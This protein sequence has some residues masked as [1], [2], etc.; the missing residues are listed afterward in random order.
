MYCC[1]VEKMYNEFERRFE[2]I[3]KLEPIITFMSYPFSEVNSLEDI[4][5]PISY[6]FDM[7]YIK[8]ESEIIKIKSDI[9]LKARGSEKQFLNLRNEKKYSCF[10]N[11]ALQLYTYFGFTYMCETAFSHMKIIKS[12][13]RPT[14]SND[15]L[16]QCLRLA[17]SNY[18]QDYNKIANDM[19]CH[20]STSK[21]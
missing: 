17:V 5:T 6:L 18:S 14:H 10:K 9:F 3:Q 4:S 15:Y 19:Q 2:D 11:V 16:E 13:Y 8:I 20:T 12:E 7:D 21:T 1:E